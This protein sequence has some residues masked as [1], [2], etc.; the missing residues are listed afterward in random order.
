MQVS[1]D[2]ACQLAAQRLANCAPGDFAL[3]ASASCS[4][5]DLAVAH[6]FTRQVMRSDAAHISAAARYGRGLGAAARLLALSQPLEALDTAGLIFCLGLDAAYAQSVVEPYLLRARA[7]GAVLLTLNAHQHVPGR[8]A[9]LW[10]KP[11]AG[12]EAALLE[13]LAA[14]QADGGQVGAALGL[15]RAAS[16]PLLLVGPGY[17][18]DLPQAVE[19][20]QAATGAAWWRW[21]RRATWAA[22]CAPPNLARRALVLAA[23]RLRPPRAPCT[24]WGPPC[25]RNWTRRPSSFFKTR[26]CPREVC[27]PLCATGWCC[28][29]RPS[30]KP[31]GSLVDHA[32]ALKPLS[33][34]VAPPGEALPGWQI[35]CR[36]ARAMGAQGFDFSSAQQ[37]SAELARQAAVMVQPDTAPGWL[38]CPDEHDFMGAPLAA[39]VEGL[40][41]LEPDLRDPQ[42]VLRDPH[43]G[44]A[45]PARGAARPHGGATRPHGGASRPHGGATRGGDACSAC[46]R[47]DP[48][49]PT[50]TRRCWLRRMWPRPPSPG[51]SSSCAPARRASASRSASRIG[52]PGRGR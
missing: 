20:L 38:A 5:E 12:G 48:W 23:R 15:L 19:R 14:G 52:T 22:P 11:P 13:E 30:A 4:S 45:R 31:E 2:E 32:G 34:A 42:G 18:A 36:I 24:W 47:I 37:V 16:R 17:L 29:W 44:A 27:R 46:W 21:R 1:W 51:S 39:W 8:F 50:C 43:R 26:T 49:C 25:R 35:L 28:P 33:A 3:V 7:R 6:K 9:D 10:L 40:R 41:D